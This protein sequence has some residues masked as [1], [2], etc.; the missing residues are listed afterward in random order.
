M[1]TFEKISPDDPRLTAFALGEM[2]PAERTEFEL[3]LKQDAAARAIVAEITG[4]AHH[5]GVALANESEPQRNGTP[6]A[7]EFR[8]LDGGAAS[9]GK[10]P[11]D[12]YA[13][14][15][16]LHFPQMYFAISGFAAACF[17]IGFVIWQ[18]SYKPQPQYTEV[19]L[20]KFPSMNAKD[21][22]EMAIAGVE[23]N[24]L[25]TK[26]SFVTVQ[27][28]PLSLFPINRAT[29]AYA[30]VRRS[31]QSG[32]LPPRNAVRIEEMVNYFPYAYSSP[33]VE[34]DG[35]FAAHLEVA[36][37]PW[38][39]EHRLVRIGLK[40]RAGAIGDTLTTIAKDVRL[41]VEFNPL[42]VQSYRL[43]G[44][45]D[46]MLRKGD[47]NNGKIDAGE[48]GA[49]HMVTALYEVVPVETPAVD[50]LKHQEPSASTPLNYSELLT[51]KVSYKEPADD[52][53]SE[54]EFPLR[55][56]GHVFDEASADFKFAASVAAFGMILRDSPHKGESTFAHVTQWAQA[57][58]MDDT[59]GYRSEF[60]GLVGQAERL[61]RN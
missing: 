36:S 8:V 2:E 12:P 40:G 17:A 52:V 5:I 59:G 34:T 26:D 22:S 48:V 54:R 60:V 53:S 35:P 10:K 1:S 55:D 27:S 46:R 25:G 19:D 45:E 7:N 11:D 56:T 58:L 21:G 39:P 33:K 14:S 38:A 13:P 37:A 9:V 44:Y 4:T 47:F 49:G 42:A 23:A 50:R 61:S 15:K 3:L 57:G 24:D 6:A 28:A 20:T 41:E 43:I 16:W 18:A 30:N 51:L 32:R 31:L 29:V